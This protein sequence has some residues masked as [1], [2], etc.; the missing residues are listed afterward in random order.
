M[1]SALS[2]TSWQMVVG[3]ILITFAVSDGNIGELLLGLAFGL[4]GIA[5][6]TGWIVLI[7]YLDRNP[8]EDTEESPAN[9]G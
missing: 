8:K 1:I 4:S 6:G 5:A 2:W 7:Y 3:A 9:A